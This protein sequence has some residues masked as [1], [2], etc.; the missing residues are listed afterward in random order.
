MKK[1]V[2]I[3]ILTAV[4]ASGLSFYFGYQQG[5][6]HPQIILVKGLSNIENGKE[7]SVDFNLFWE[8]WQ[9]L[10]KNYADA[11]KLDNQNL[12][13]GAISGLFR[14]T[15]D[16]YSVFM[17]PSEAKN[18]NEEIS[19][20]FGGI[21]AE[22]GIRNEELT[23]ITPIKGTPAEKAGL[24]AGDKILK[25]NDTITA[26]LTVDE[27][28]SKIKGQK[29]TKVVLT[30]FRKEWSE[31]KEISITRDTIQIPTLDSKNLNYEG[32]EDPKGKI[33]YLQLYN[34]YEKSP[35]LFY[36]TIV[37]SLFNN[38]PKGI[39]IDLRNNPGGYLEAA[40]NIAGWFMDRGQLVVS[41]KFNFGNNK[42]F[43]T[44]GTE[45]FK[46]TPVV[47]LINQGSASASEILAGTLRDNRGIKL[48]GNKSF[49]KGSVQQMI[50]LGNNSEAKITIARWLTPKG[51]LIDKE[52]LKPDIEVNITQQDVESGKDPQLEKAV[53]ILN[54]EIK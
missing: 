26:G 32:K 22:I 10:K 9:A 8:A 27:A 24:T 48:V 20:E 42:E 50:P 29:G 41:E 23:V 1:I 31:P 13:Y 43:R 34:F 51:N 30:M 16:P 35:L 15:K 49:G 3:T 33:M 14:A 39:I 52:G 54:S 40:V 36:N 17:P 6:K 12:V 21:G 45:L 2:L 4:A 46:N 19:G 38:N 18:F 44:D 28:V 47:V 5:I 7:E 37:K 11:D 53:E 25:I